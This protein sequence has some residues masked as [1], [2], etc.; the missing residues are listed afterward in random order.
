MARSSE[1]PWKVPGKWDTSRHNW[2]EEVRKDW[3][4]PSHVT[5]HDVTN[6]DGEQ[7]PGIVFGVKEKLNIA[8]A[9]ADMGVE[10]IEGGMAAV[11]PDDAEAISRMAKELKGVEIATFARTR[12]DDCDLA[13]K[14]GVGRIIMEIPTPI[15]RINAIW[16]STEKAVDALV[17]LTQY[18][19]SQ[20]LNCTLFLLSTML[21]DPEHL[22]KLIIP[23]V[24][25]GGADRV[26]AVDTSGVSLPQSM[27]YIVRK[28]K[29]WVDVPIE[30]HVHNTFGCATAGTLASVMA[31]AE[32][33]HTCVNGLG[34]NAPLDECVMGLEAL[35]GIDSGIK[36]KQ[37]MALSDMVREY[38]KRD[39]FK[40]FSGSKTR[41]VETGLSTQGM[42]ARKQR[43]EEPIVDT[44]LIETVGGGGYTIVLGKKSGRYSM[45]FKAEELGLPVPEQK[46]AYKMLDQVK[47]LSNKKLG[48]V[49]DDEFKEIYHNVM[50]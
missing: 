34:G 30:V 42:W 36:T 15:D 28:I 10:R 46:D 19:K 31:G 40:P 27:F 2:T 16:G 37:L 22:K 35:L 7:T 20:G 6:R 11:S 9:L 5:I 29:S 26:C 13:V 18:V 41:L 3:T 17:E 45:M 43:G 14:C 47:A 12:K 1:T 4:L 48:P 50:G 44:S 23:T 8:H 32:V 39:W 24:E 21:S 25:Q 33:I 38:A 49:D